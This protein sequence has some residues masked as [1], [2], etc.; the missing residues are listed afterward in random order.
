MTATAGSDRATETRPPRPPGRIDRLVRGFVRGFLL[1][2]ADR[3]VSVVAVGWLALAALG[4]LLHGR[5]WVLTFPQLLPPIMYLAVPAALVVLAVLLRPRRLRVV[6][7]LAGLLL[8]A[9]QSGLNVAA[10]APG[11]GPAPAAALRVLSWNTEVWTDAAGADRHY[12]FLRAQ[13]ADVYLLQEYQPFAD[14]AQ[15]AADLARIRA[16]FPGYTMVTRGELL[17]LSRLPVASV[18][19]LP[20][21]PP[22]GSSWYVEY[23][24][25]KALRTDLLVG[26]RILS[27]YNVHMP[28]P[29]DLTSPLRGRFYQEVQDRHAHRV[30]DYRALEADIRRDGHPVLVGGDFNTG[31]AMGGLHAAH[32]RLRDAARAGRT[33][34]YPL[35]WN[36]RWPAEP[37]RLDWAFTSPDVR[38]HRYRFIDPQGQSDHRAQQLVISLRG[39]A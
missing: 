36:A 33:M 15:Q 24:T 39:A 23:Q 5:S 14:R 37:W 22:A 34:L 1:G 28:I 29:L 2:V 4:P 19:A 32:L 25:V 26:G 30:V 3:V 31:Q 17:T 12:R 8:G 9:A 6:L 7:A 11:P 10:L 35:S 38:V 20:T 27:V 21:D 18:T 13:H 16:A